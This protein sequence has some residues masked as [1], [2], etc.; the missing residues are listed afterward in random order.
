M[1][2]DFDFNVRIN[3]LK[4]QRLLGKGGFGE[5][6]LCVDELTGDMVAVKH[7]S[8]EGQNTSSQM[9][10]KEVKALMGLQHKHI[11]KLLDTFPKP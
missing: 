9:L 11:V 10:E 4:F 2:E 1:G 6:K 7:L 5:V 8:Y 3:A